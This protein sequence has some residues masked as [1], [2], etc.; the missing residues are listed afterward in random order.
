MSS[1][2]T[3]SDLV[4]SKE[5]LDNLGSLAKDYTLPAVLATAGTGILGASLASKNIIGHETKAE[6]RKR[7]LR[8]ALFPALTTAAAITALGGAHAVSTLDPL[9]LDETPSGNAF[10]FIAKN[11]GIPAGVAL[12]AKKTGLK[13]D[14]FDTKTKEGLRK[15]KETP[16]IEFGKDLKPEDKNFTGFGKMPKANTKSSI[17]KLIRKIKTQP[18]I[19]FKKGLLDTI[20]LSALAGLGGYATDK[21][22]NTFLY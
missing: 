14:L 10:D 1:E 9:K 6:R 13:V 7:I 12:G 2:K 17:G 20:T 21:F 15:A 4:S 16:F 22:I 11:I 3:I 5:F 19:S 8:S 18:R